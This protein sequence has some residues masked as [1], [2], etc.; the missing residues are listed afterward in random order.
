M[1]QKEVPITQKI[2][3]EH[4]YNDLVA[5]YEKSEFEQRS[6]IYLDDN[7]NALIRSQSEFEDKVCFGVYEVTP[8]FTT[9]YYLRYNAKYGFTYSKKT[10]TVKVWFGKPMYTIS[11]ELRLALINFISTDLGHNWLDNFDYRLHLTVRVINKILKGK[12]TNPRDCLAELFKEKHPK[13][14]FSK[15]LLWKFSKKAPQILTHCISDPRYRLF[16]TCTHVDK[17]LSFLIENP[18]DYFVN[19]DAID[20]INQAQGLGI[21]L[22]YCWSEKRMEEVHSELSERIA[23]EKAKTMVVTNFGYEG[24]FP[25]FPGLSLITDNKKLFIE[26]S[27]MHHCV[28]T[29]YESRIMNKKYFVLSYN[30]G[31]YRGTVGI[32]GR[33]ASAIMGLPKFTIE[34]FRGTRNQAMP[35]EI[36]DIITKFVATDPVQEFFNQNYNAPDRKA[37]PTTEVALAQIGQ[38]GYPNLLY[39]EDL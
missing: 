4:G 29:N 25:A 28:Y 19:T 34:Q 20:L 23:N 12:I 9:K 11:Q 21:K 13:I 27:V 22:S 10:K 16:D 2:L 33:N 17:L 3:Y 1:K 38:A 5:L 37:V 15:E 18:Y 30:D 32:V 6:R 8:K 7:P 31:E 24:E 35:E 26:G 36:R 39:E 14:S